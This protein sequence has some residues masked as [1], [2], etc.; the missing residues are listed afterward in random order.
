MKLKRTFLLLCLINFALV[1]QA[2]SVKI[3]GQVVDS[4]THKSEPFTTIRVFKSKI[5]DTPIKTLVT[6][7]D[8]KFSLILKGNGTYFFTFNSVGRK[9]ICKKVVIDKSSKEVFNFGILLVQDDPKQL[10]AVTVTA[11]KPIV[12]MD[13]DKMTYDV[14]NDVDSK[15]NTLL[16]MLRK[17]PMVS[18][19]GQDNITVNGKSSFKVYI[20]GKPNAMFSSNTSQIFKSI[21]A[22]AVKSIEVITNPGAKYDAEGIGGILNIIMNNRM[23]SN[24]NKNIHYGSIGASLRSFGYSGDV[25]LTGQN[26]KL[27]YSI[28]GTYSMHDMSKSMRTIVEREYTDKTLMIYDQDPS[29]N[30]PYLMGNLNLNYQI[31]SNSNIGATVGLSKFVMKNESAP[32]TIFRN[33][34]FDKEIS[35]NAKL[36]SIYKNFSLNTSVDY[37]Y[38]FNK[39]RTKIL[40]LSYMLNT[41]PKSTE[42]NKEYSF[43]AKKFYGYS[44]NDLKSLSN[45]NNIS[46]TFQADYTTP[47]SK[48]NILNFGA[49]FINYTNKSDSKFFDI[50]NKEEKYNPAASVNYNNSQ[51]IFA[52]YV[53]YNISTEK[54]GSK[55]GLRYEHTWSDVEF[56]L[57]KG[58]NFKQIYGNLVPSVSF[59]YIISKMMNVGINYNLRISRPDISFLN[60]YIDRTRSTELIY[61]NPNLEVEKSHN[62]SVVYNTFTPKFMLNLTLSQSI[63]GNQIS[64]YSFVDN[65][66]LLNTTYGNI[67]KYSETGLSSFINYALFA[68]TRLTLNASVSYNDI[69]TIKTAMIKQSNSGWMMNAFLG[70]QQTLPLD[71]KLAFYTGGLTRRYNLQ[72][73]SR[74]FNYYSVTLSKSLF[75]EK[76]DLSLNVIGSYDKRF[77]QGSY[78]IGNGFNY[79]KVSNIVHDKNYMIFSLTWKFGNNKNHFNT[80]KSNITNDFKEQKTDSNIGIISVE[81]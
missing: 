71:F 56:K 22:S 29:L 63:S 36:S 11:Q 42:N 14:Q 60:P 24:N 18:V 66:G 49:K 12:K 48:G 51:N 25:F 6:N 44:M 52:S 69:R 30:I 70:I 20:D 4:I 32:L 13:V 9:E 37:N 45:I 46:H 55:F 80:H 28:N 1:L 62:L 78:S 81:N 68:K 26:N 38:Y 40:V 72:G 50:I 39:N 27:T 79:Q 19:D 5:S 75:N 41:S 67:L 43:E 2:Q 58:S 15:S 61:G 47:I 34:R 35:Y 76:L 23:S 17:V 10:S 3:V 74:G 65:N 53:E 57:G 73:Y 64:S 54:I 8:G 7:N 31:N 16:N 77:T 33:G 59:K 21:P